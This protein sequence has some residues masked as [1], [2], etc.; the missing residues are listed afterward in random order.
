MVNMSYC[1]HENTYN[2]LKE[3]YEQWDEFKKDE[4]SEYEVRGRESLIALIKDMAEDY[5]VSEDGDE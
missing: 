3:V 1:R 4:S 5:G 2:A